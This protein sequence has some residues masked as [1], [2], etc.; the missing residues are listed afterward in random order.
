MYWLN[1]IWREMRNILVISSRG[2]SL[3]TVPGEYVHLALGWVSR[4]MVRLPQVKGE[5]I[6]R[7]G[8]SRNRSP[9]SYKLLLFLSWCRMT[10]R[11]SPNK[12]HSVWLIW[13]G[14]HPVAEKLGYNWIKWDLDF[15]PLTLFLLRLTN[16]Y[17]NFKMWKMFVLIPRIWYLIVKTFLQLLNGYNL[18][19]MTFLLFLKHDCS[20]IYCNFWYTY[21]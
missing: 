19:G 20:S 2:T 16:R 18:G 10:F 1:A 13:S 12:R 6:H 21:K 8:N 11:C 17:G 9:V 3:Q 14:L 7:I 5:I 15:W 4:V